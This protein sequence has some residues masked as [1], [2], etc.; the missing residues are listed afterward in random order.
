MAGSASLATAP[1]SRDLPLW[2]LGLSLRKGHPAGRRPREQLLHS[3]ESCLLLL[4]IDRTVIDQLI[5]LALGCCHTSPT[6]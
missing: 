1:V 3:L 5:R 2:P 4:E 6:F